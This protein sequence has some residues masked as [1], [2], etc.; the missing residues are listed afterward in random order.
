[1]STTQADPTVRVQSGVVSGKT[2]DDGLHVFRG[3]PYAAPPFGA[4]RFQPP[5]PPESWDGIRDATRSGVAAPQPAT[6][7]DDP[8]APMYAPTVTGEDCLTLDIWTPELGATGLPVVVH[9]HGGGYMTGSG[10]LPLYSGRAFARDGIV[11]V[12]INYRLGIE[13][14]LYLGDGHDSLGLR[15]QI[16]ALEWVQRNIAAFGGDPDHVTIMGQSAGGVS[17][18]THL[19]MPASVGLFHQAIAQ[20]G[21]TIASTDIAT[22]ERQT[23][24]VARWL[25]VPAT[26]EGLREVSLERTTAAAQKLATRF[27]LRLLRGDAEALMVT[28]FRAVHG[29]SLL[30]TMPLA[31]AAHSTPPLLAGTVQNETIG[32]IQA[33]TGMPILG[34]LT[35]RGLRRA[36]RIDAAKRAAYAAEKLTDPDVM[37]DAAWTEWSFSGPTRRFVEA[38]PGKSWLYEFR[39]HA[40]S[41]PVGAVHGIEL[42]FSADT[43]DTIDLLGTDARK[44]FDGAPQA[45]A[46]DMHGA[47]TAFV[48]AGDPGWS[49]HS[50][51]TSAPKAFGF[52]A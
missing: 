5:V 6:A 1:M 10:S 35:R 30:P 45:L 39:W 23:R 25:R 21:S 15:D 3:I 52:S 28:P 11:H 50:D 49:R 31:S 44:Y 4:N 2:H 26:V 38:R 8:W 27:L 14:F 46:D 34:G 36:L 16:A 20:S 17:V 48:R 43:L 19:A 18:F 9:I 32:F 7:P 40:P 51:A 37:S 47:F 42:P 24:A 33:M 29:T 12:S 13:G 41:E 22:A